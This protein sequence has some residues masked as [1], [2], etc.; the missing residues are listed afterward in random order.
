SCCTAPVCCAHGSSFPSRG[1]I[2]DRE[3]V[4]RLV[5]SLQG[6]P[7]VLRGDLDRTGPW[8]YA[9]ASEAPVIQSLGEPAWD[10]A[11]DSEG[12]TRQQALKLAALVIVDRHVA[13]G[14]MQCP[15]LHGGEEPVA[16]RAEVLGVVLHVV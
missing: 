7:E 6:E 4:D 2:A 12:I 13:R 3:Q 11:P 10:Q 8:L 16:Q 1:A 15:H 9:V 5:Q 14:G